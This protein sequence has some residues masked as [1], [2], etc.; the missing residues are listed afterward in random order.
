[1]V[2]ASSKKTEL[3]GS[4]TVSDVVPGHYTATVIIGKERRTHAKAIVAG[5]NEIDLADL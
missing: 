1:V 4:F 5:R 3:D 2:A